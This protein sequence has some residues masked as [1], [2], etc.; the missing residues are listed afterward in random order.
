MFLRAKQIWQVAEHMRHTVSIW[1]Y[2]GTLK[3]LL[4]CTTIK[5]IIKDHLGRKL[6]KMLQFRTEAN[7]IRDS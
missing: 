3:L 7:R 2:F 1:K 6:A 5:L 4:Q